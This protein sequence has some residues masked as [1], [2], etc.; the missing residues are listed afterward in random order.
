MRN[1]KLHFEM[2][3]I[4]NVTTLREFRPEEVVIESCHVTKSRASKMSFN[5][6]HTFLVFFFNGNEMLADQTARYLKA[7]ALRINLSMFQV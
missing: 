4:V 2:R 5:L 1:I 7:E 6:Q 3:N